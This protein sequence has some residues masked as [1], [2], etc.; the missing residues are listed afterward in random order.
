MRKHLSLLILLTLAGTACNWFELPEQAVAVSTAAHEGG[1]EDLLIP[2]GFDFSTFNTINVSVAAQDNQGNRLINIPFKVYQETE[3]AENL[4]LTATTG[5][6]GIFEFELE[7]ASY[8]EQMILT[9]T[10]PGL[11]NRYAFSV[12]ED[13]VQLILGE[14]E[15]RNVVQGMTQQSSSE[16]V[17]RIQSAKLAQLRSS[18]FSYL[19]TYDNQGVPDYLEPEDDVVSQGI[20]DLIANSLPEGQPVPVYNPQYI[21]DAANGNT[22][23]QADADL[24]V[25]FVHEGA[26]YLNALGY[27][28]YPTGNP[29]SRPEEVSDFKIIFPN[30][31]YSGSGG[32]LK[33]GNKV[34]LG[35][36]EKG[37]SVGWFLIPNGWNNRER[38]VEVEANKPIKYSLPNFNDFTASEYQNH[39]VLLKS[40]ADEILMLGFEDVARPGG[41]NDF[42]DAI[43]IVS[44]N[45]FSA[46]TTDGVVAAQ[47]GSADTDADGVADAVDEFSE[48]PAVAF[49]NYAPAK[50][51]F[52]SLAF[53]DRWPQKG[54]YD[55][56]D[57]VVDYNFTEYRDAEN[58]VIKLRGI[59]VL[60]AI[61]AGFQ[62]GFGVELGI[63]PDRIQSVRGSVL[64]E[65][66]IQLAA[67][68]LE[69]GQERAVMIV[70][71]NANKILRNPQGGFVN[72]E[73]G[74]PQVE[75]DTIVMDIEL[76]AP[77]LS[78]E[79][80]VAPYNPFLIQNLQRGVEVHLLNG[81]PTSKANTRLLGTGQDA[82]LVN[83]E[84]YYRSTAGLP[85]GV[86][87]ARPFAWPLEKESVHRAYLKFGE[88][89]QSGGFNYPDWYLPNIGYRNETKIY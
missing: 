72:T 50:D 54:D 80:G 27:F 23:L 1:I 30:V 52:G 33:T 9:T 11:P 61:G 67:N 18:N 6:Q 41:D 82:S 86:K 83:Q 88:W 64:N 84:Q 34:Y 73:Q 78:S 57:L 85:W 15:G 22:A 12:K 74:R 38:K 7:V 58:R 51:Q 45:P 16:L 77:L 26:G 25:T 87:L 10:Y 32:G 17:R 35:R 19:G 70:F 28:T 31:S 14:K 37:T 69:A 47:L 3:A 48:D 2:E 75:P 79:L 5:P 36:F 60:K 40:E 44:A 49:V 29:P 71:D 21:A 62:N 59:F 43:F 13:P 53:E 68:G 39:N 24:W 4:L 20:L 55:F 65:D 76:T 81:R 89:A 8:T 42:N 63:S 66:Y 46:I 56:N